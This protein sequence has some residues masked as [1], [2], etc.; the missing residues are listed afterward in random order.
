MALSKKRV[1][2]LL[3][4]FLSVAIADYQEF[5]RLGRQVQDRQPAPQRRLRPVL[6]KKLGAPPPPPAAA[7]ASRQQERFTDFDNYRPNFRPD[8][9]EYD[10]YGNRKQYGNAN[11]NLRRGYNKPQQPA[12]ESRGRPAQQERPRPVYPPPQRTVDAKR[13]AVID[14]IDPQLLEELEMNPAPAAQP[15]QDTYVPASGPAY[16]SPSNL[17]PIYADARNDLAAGALEASVIAGANA[18]GGVA[19]SPEGVYQN[20]DRLFFQIH[21]QEG[22]HSYRYGYD[23]GNGYNRQFRYEER[24]AEGYVKGRYGFYDKHGQL[25]VINYHADPVHGFHAEGAGVPKYP[26]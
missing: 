12:A 4:V 23:T 8:G 22:P 14:E 9:A 20:E 3:S 1:L 15:R 24:T 16:A 21:G 5:R 10:E 13:K 17:S 26:H 2:I 19:K 18:Y 25:Q 6:K 7:A 11:G